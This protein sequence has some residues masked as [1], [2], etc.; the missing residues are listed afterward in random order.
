MTTK[1]KATSNSEEAAR[2][3]RDSVAKALDIVGDRWVFLILRE[4]FFGVRRYDELRQNIGASPTVLADRLR[5]L[6]KA[7]IFK[8]VRYSDHKNRYD[9]HL[10]EKGLDLYPTIVML[11]A[12]GDRWESGKSGPPLRLIHRS[13]GHTLVP[14]VICSACEKPIEARDV[15][16]EARTGSKR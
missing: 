9:Y 10:T 13:C 6:V 14:R 4:A 3:L 15:R 2:P 11:M 16:W 1:K 8:R 5:R 7:K 12:W